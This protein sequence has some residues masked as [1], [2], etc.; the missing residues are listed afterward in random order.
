LSSRIK[1]EPQPDP[2]ISFESGD[3]GC[4]VEMTND[5]GSLLSNRIKIAPQPDLEISF[6]VG[7]DGY[8]AGD[9]TC[10]SGIRPALRPHQH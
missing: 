2:E 7:D 10:R 4:T 9:C 5:G 3:C 1:I 8:T 6:E